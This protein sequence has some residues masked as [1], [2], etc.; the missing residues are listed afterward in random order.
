MM[1]DWIEPQPIPEWLLSMLPA[2][3]DDH[4]NGAAFADDVIPE[5]RRDN[6]LTSFAGSMRRQGMTEEEMATALLALNSSRCVPPLPEDQVY[7]IA[8]SIAKYPPEPTVGS[9]NP[10]LQQPAV[11]TPRKWP[12]SLAPG[13]FHGLA[14]DIVRAIAPHT[15]ADAASL[16]LQFLASFGNALGRGPH[17]VAESDRH[18]T[19]IDIVLVGET[20]KGRKGSS[21]GRVKD[22]LLQADRQWAEH[23]IQNG[24]LS[25][26]EGLIWAVRDSIE[27]MVKPKEGGAYIAVIVD[28]GVADKRL[29]II[30]SEFASTLKVMSRE[31]NTLSPIMRQAWDAGTL[32]ILTKNSPARATDAH[33]STIGHVTK[34]ELIRYLTDTEAG[35][36]FANRFLWVCSRR[37]RVLP[38]GGG[39]VEYG[40]IVPRLHEA[41]ERGRHMEVLQRD[42]EARQAWAEVYQALSEGKPGLFGAVVARGE[43][44]VLRLSVIYAVLDGEH[45]VRLP[46]LMA[47]LAVW[48]YCEASARYI[49]GD[50]TGDSV[51]DRI[52]EG[53]RQ[54]P[55]GLS[56]TGVGWQ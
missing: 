25:S 52:M 24:G 3:R 6:T 12:Q 1:E 38:E 51:A 11:S 10:I 42:E 30:E 39:P 35:N 37:A 7:K 55:T 41:L 27:K 43:A 19:N 4:Q 48:D 44:Q 2:R 32:S 49:F 8:R 22:L 23:C 18:G 45:V 26:G 50:A 28:A 53:L 29:L 16:L 34:D 15:E 56:R 9:A 40:N 47:A 36:G 5:G 33:I 20:S 54:S 13:A 21:W 17:G 46:H 14:G 31:G